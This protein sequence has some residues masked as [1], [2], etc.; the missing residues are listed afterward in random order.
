MD[1]LIQDGFHG[2]FWDIVSGA[3]K[4]VGL[5]GIPQTLLGGR[6]VP[7]GGTFKGIGL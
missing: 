1:A 4:R 6:G 2:R 5:I 3:G 7:S